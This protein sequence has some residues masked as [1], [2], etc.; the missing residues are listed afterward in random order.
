MEHIDWFLD[1][2]LKNKNTLNLSENMEL[3][4]V[5][6]KHN[7]HSHA[8][9]KEEIEN[10]NHQKDP[11][12]WNS[13]KNAKI[14]AKKIKDFLVK[15]RGEDKEIFQKNYEIFT[16]SINKRVKDFKIKTKWKRQNY[17]IVFHDAHNYLFRDLGIDNKKKRV[18]RKSV[19]NE[20]NSKD[21][22]D[23]IEEIK[24]HNIK[25]A[26]VEP[27]FKSASFSRL[28]KKYNIKIY[29]LDP[30][31]KDE[32]RGWYLKNLNNNLKSLEKIFDK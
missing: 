27:Q 7:H 1:K 22:Q 25:I 12:I 8:H 20:P 24:E 19:L 31:G 26:F 18:F 2:K 15:L 29:T 13:P 3:L 5:W 28:A 16:E 10:K 11:H 6:E 30:L 9:E 14:I 32:N 17:F 21:M 23:L 4:E